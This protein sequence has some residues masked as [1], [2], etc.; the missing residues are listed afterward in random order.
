MTRKT[1]RIGCSVET[2]C[3]DLIHTA[4]LVCILMVALIV[5][6]DY[7]RTALNLIGRP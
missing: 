3:R 4:A 7:F 2:V 1:F 6:I 5:A